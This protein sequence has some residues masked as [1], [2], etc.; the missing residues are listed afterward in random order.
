MPRFPARPISPS[1][2]NSRSRRPPAAATG[3]DRGPAAATAI[4]Q[5][6]NPHPSYPRKTSPPDATR[7]ATSPGHGIPG[8]P[9]THRNPDPSGTHGTGRRAH[10][11]RAASTS[12]AFGESVFRQQP[13]PLAFGQVAGR[14]DLEVTPVQGGDFVQ[15]E[16][17]GKRYH[18]GVDC[19][20]PEG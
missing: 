19:L 16:P 10:I 17:F 12:C 1:A 2:A 18:A 5:L 7:Q 15:V 14:D 11:L 13:E 6:V 3:P 8:H 20:K 4:R 9:P